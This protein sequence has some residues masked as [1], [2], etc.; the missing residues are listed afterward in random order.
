MF[1]YGGQDSV[2]S[3]VWSPDSQFIASGDAHGFVH[4]WQAC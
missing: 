2:Q 1:I 3:I 4:V